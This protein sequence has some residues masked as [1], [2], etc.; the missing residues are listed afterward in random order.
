MCTRWLV[1]VGVRCA[2]TRPRLLDMDLQC[3]FEGLTSPRTPL[4]GPRCR[5]FSPTMLRWVL[6]L[7]G[8]GF[9]V[10]LGGRRGGPLRAWGRA[11][12]RN[13]S[14]PR[15]A[16]S[17]P[18]LGLGF[19]R[20]LGASLAGAR[21]LPP[22]RVGPCSGPPFLVAPGTGVVICLPVLVSLG[23]LGSRW[24]FKWT[25]SPVSYLGFTGGIFLSVVTDLAGVCV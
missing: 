25:L 6:T 7:G 13:A 2:A 21:G 11:R 16:P 9:P 18:L 22:V 24:I 17:P 8:L 19:L 20:P 10:P 3:L 15:W 12:R 14:G 5:A 23:E 1:I 4:T